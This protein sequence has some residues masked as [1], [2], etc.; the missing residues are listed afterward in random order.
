MVPLELINLKAADLSG[1]A[2]VFRCPIGRG[3]AS[4]YRVLQ[5]GCWRRKTSGDCATAQLLGRRLPALGIGGEPSSRELDRETA[6]SA[7]VHINENSPDASQPESSPANP[8][9]LLTDDGRPRIETS[10][11]KRLNLSD[12][13]FDAVL[14]NGASLRASE[15]RRL[16]TEASG[17]LSFEIDQEDER[18][19]AHLRSNMR[20]QF[21]PDQS[22]V[23][24]HHCLE[25]ISPA[26]SPAAAGGEIPPDCV[27]DM[28]AN[29]V[30]ETARRAP[31][32]SC[33]LSRCAFHLPARNRCGMV[34]RRATG[35]RQ[36]ELTPPP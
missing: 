24:L 21:Y 22:F 30:G 19:A 20:L 23:K 16:Q 34:Q 15:V 32:S 36:L 8:I 18:G 35:Q 26:L 7:S 17:A 1:I 25:V 31:C 9:R 3:G 6:L 27:D 13:R 10:E 12:L 33:V 2:I 28:R 29:I 5:Y 11:G 14:A 4:S